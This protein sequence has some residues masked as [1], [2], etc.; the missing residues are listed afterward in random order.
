MI[1]SSPFGPKG[2]AY[3]RYEQRL[4]IRL[5]RIKKVVG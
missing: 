4:A 2:R 1:P 5:R 3:F